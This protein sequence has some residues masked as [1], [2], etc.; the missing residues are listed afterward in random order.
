MF[1]QK[2]CTFLD[3]TVVYY[4]QPYHISTYF[5][6]AQRN[7]VRE[8]PIKE[9]HFSSWENKKYRYFPIDKCLIIINNYEWCL[10]TNMHVQ[11]ML[12]YSNK[13]N[14]NKNIPHCLNR[15][16]NVFVNR[17]TMLEI[18]FFYLF[19]IF[20]HCKQCTCIFF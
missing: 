13:I 5:T 16:K 14:L 8:C 15:P 12:Q 6:T 2:H 3:H 10:C 7:R 18:A 20:C 11:L 17:I 9:F 1:I 19:D 4:C